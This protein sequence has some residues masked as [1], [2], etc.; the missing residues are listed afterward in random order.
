MSFGT[1]MVA[2]SG[3]ARSCSR[4]KE[5]VSSPTDTCKTGSAASAKL[6][7]TSKRQPT[8]EPRIKCPPCG[9]WNSARQRS[10]HLTD[11]RLDPLPIPGLDV[12]VLLLAFGGLLR[13]L[14]F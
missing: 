10:P 12:V 13:G 6:E 11:R 7:V 5:R 1:S 14:E 9:N 2:A 3:L 4:L 8:I